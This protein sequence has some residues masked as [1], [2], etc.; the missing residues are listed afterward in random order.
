VPRFEPFPGIRYDTARVP[1]DAVVAPPYDVLSAADRAALASRD[2]HNVVTIDV[3][4][5]ADGPGRYEEAGARWRDWRSEGVLVTDREPAFYLYRRAFVDPLG[6]ARRSTGVLGGLEVQPAGAGADVLPHEQ[7]TPKDSTDR[8]ELTR[9][10]EANLSPVWGLSLA[11]G[12]GA[13]CAAPGYLLGEVTDEEGV[14]HRLER[15]DDPAR[16]EQ[17]HSL[18]ASAPVV[19][20]DGHHRYGVARTYRDE[21]R[22]AAGDQPG[23]YDLTLTFVVELAEDQLTVQAIHRLLTGVALDELRD[24]L[25]QSF[26]L[27]DA[28]PV[29]VGIVDELAHRGALCL[30]APD[31]TGTFLT[32]KPEAFAGGRDLDSARLD[33]ALGDLA[34]TTTY[35]H[36]VDHVL[37]ALAAGRADAAVLLRPVTVA[38]IAATAHDHALMP[39]KSTFFW[40]KLKTGLL[41]R[42]VE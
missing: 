6:R 4:L 41:F 27:T 33:A 19:I 26:T 32:P 11:E 17:L 39:P 24:R 18:V 22:A 28:G 36:G 30:V 35:Q 23:P 37:E 31:G 1:L 12:L 16:V 21:R 8:L 3:P 13:A 20:A 34:R 15:V 25:A 14:T 9:A 5:E 42:S 38:Q 2:P 29:S 40:P 10:T 7:T